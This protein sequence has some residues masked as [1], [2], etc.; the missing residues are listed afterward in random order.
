MGALPIVHPPTIDV[1]GHLDSEGKKTSKQLSRQNL[2]NRSCFF[3]LHHCSK[4]VF[5]ACSF[6]LLPQTML[7]K[8]IKADMLPLVH[9]TR[10]LRKPL[11]LL[12]HQSCDVN[13]LFSLCYDAQDIGLHSRIF[14]RAASREQGDAD[15]ELNICRELSLCKGGRKPFICPIREDYLLAFRHLAGGVPHSVQ[16]A[17]KR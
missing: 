1:Y 4:S 9:E 13:W 16:L 8:N 10:W 12:H 15:R 7:K 2:L 17:K 5:L 14:I 6:D 11:N 3:I